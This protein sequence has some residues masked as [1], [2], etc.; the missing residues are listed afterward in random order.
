MLIKRYSPFISA[1]WPNL[2]NTDKAKG[3][4]EKDER[5]DGRKE[6]E[7]GRD[8]EGTAIVKR[9]IYTKMK[10]PLKVI[11]SKILD[12]KFDFFIFF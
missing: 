11:N 12:K 10:N 8:E 7:D 4:E 1:F 9:K 5:S 2:P 3:E 6:A